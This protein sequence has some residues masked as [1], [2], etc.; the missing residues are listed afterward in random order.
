MS[1][2]DEPVE[3]EVE[4]VLLEDLRPELFRMI[5]NQ[6]T[7]LFSMFEVLCELLEARGVM[8]PG[9]KDTVIRE[10]IRRWRDEVGTK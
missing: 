1:A 2:E 10:G 9:E 7:V 4:E 5:Y 6:P 8:R 3:E